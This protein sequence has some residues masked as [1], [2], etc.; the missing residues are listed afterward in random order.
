MKIAGEMG[1][2][3]PLRAIASV[4]NPFDMWLCINLM[5]GTGYEKALVKELTTQMITRAKFDLSEE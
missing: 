5:R 4:N 1:A 3:F 2:D